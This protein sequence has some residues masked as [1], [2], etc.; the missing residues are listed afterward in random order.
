MTRRKCEE[1]SAVKK[2]VRHSKQT[3]QEYH[4]VR[5]V[6]DS[7][8]AMQRK[9]IQKNEQ[10][11]AQRHESP[12]ALPQER[13]E[14]PQV[15]QSMIL[16]ALQMRNVW[17]ASQTRYQCHRWQSL[18]SSAMESMRQRVEQDM[19]RRAGHG[20]HHLVD[21]S[22][23]GDTHCSTSFALLISTHTLSP[24]LAAHHCLT[25]ATTTGHTS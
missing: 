7:W 2:T 8:A 22:T 9:H 1:K 17:C 11:D 10:G 5:T 6:C 14:T 20:S 12:L 16:R 21:R 15:E 25:S 4:D 24:F 3:Y 23:C 19:L 13:T 18:S